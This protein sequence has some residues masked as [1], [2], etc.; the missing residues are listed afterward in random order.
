MIAVTLAVAISISVA[1][2]LDPVSSVGG[3]V[4]ISVSA[5][6]LFLLA[7]INSVILYKILRDRRRAKVCSSL[8]KVPFLT[9]ELIFFP[10]IP[11]YQKGIV[12]EQTQ[13]WGCMGRVARP[14]LKLIDRPWKLYPIGILFGFG[15]E[16]C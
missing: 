2:K 9:F 5:S 11:L 8:R 15:C 10:C 7:I 3:I 13:I 1:N 16:H 14:L 4:G 6:F 12:S